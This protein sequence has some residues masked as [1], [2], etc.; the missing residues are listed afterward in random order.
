MP[1]GTPRVSIGLPVY[2][3]QT[4]LEPAIETLLAQTFTDFELVLVDNASTDRTGEICRAFAARDSRVRY[5]RNPTNIG[6]APNFNL[7]FDL[8]SAAPLFKWAAHDD[9]HQPDFLAECV[10][11][12]DARPEVVLCH[13]DSEFIDG[14]GKPFAKDDPEMD[15]LD[16]PRPSKRFRDLVISRH[17][18]LDM[19]GVMRRTELAKTPKMAG[20]VGSDRTMLAEMGLLG[21]FHRVPRTLF[22]VRDHGDR[23]SKAVPPH[24]RGAWF[25]PQLKGAVSL[26]HWRYFIE[27]NRSIWKVPLDARE[28][29]AC[30]AALVHWLG[31]NRKWLGGDLRLAYQYFRDKSRAGA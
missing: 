7:A 27:Y 25:N 30:S 22:Q 11:V 17:F 8:A 28:R 4:Y 26:E 3:G 15:H 29:L 14:Q 2:N 13:T 31:R 19:F 12:L 16:D 1:S 21:R 6:G 18:C 9:I 10:A 20:F 24:L 23:S 5:H